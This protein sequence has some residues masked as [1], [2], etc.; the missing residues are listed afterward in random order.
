MS[1]NIAKATIIFYKYL[2]LRN[3][4]SATLKLTVDNIEQIFDLFSEQTKDLFLKDIFNHAK[5]YMTIFKYSIEAVENMQINTIDQARKKFVE[6]IND[7]HEIGSAY[8]KLVKEVVVELIDRKD[9]FDI[10]DPTMG[11]GSF[12]IEANKKNNISKFYG[13]EKDLASLNIAKMQMVMHRI[14]KDKI[15]FRQNDIFINPS[16]RNEFYD[17]IISEPPYDIEPEDLKSYA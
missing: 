5:E 2:N 14:S 7:S 10:Y 1:T 9:P 16:L 12:L 11:F 15:D 17:V 8:H 4:P 13:D 6:I 3:Y